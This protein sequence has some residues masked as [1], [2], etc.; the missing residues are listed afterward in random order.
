MAAYNRVSYEGRVDIYGGWLA[1]TS[2]R[3]IPGG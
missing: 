2:V 1:G 3:G